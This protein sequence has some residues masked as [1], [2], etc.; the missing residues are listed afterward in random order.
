MA[1]CCDCPPGI[2]VGF[3]LKYQELQIGTT[4]AMVISASQSL[5]EIDTEKH[6][7]PKGKIHQVPEARILLLPV[8]L[9]LFVGFFSPIV[10]SALEHTGLLLM[11][12]TV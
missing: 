7:K 1:V 4:D 5:R 9:L 12:K 8:L 2:S 6:L 11:I 3:S 10:F